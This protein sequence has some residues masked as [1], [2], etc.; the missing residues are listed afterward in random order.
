MSAGT[1]RPQ[2]YIQNV[3]QLADTFNY[4]RGSHSFKFGIEGGKKYIAPT[5]GLPR[6][7][8][9]AGLHYVEPARERLRSQRALKQALRGA[10]R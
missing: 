6:A 4:I 1:K 5:D 10:L 7:R 9:R 8:A 2:S 3:Y